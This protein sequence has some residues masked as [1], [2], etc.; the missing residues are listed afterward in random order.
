MGYIE[1]DR[2]INYN[3]AVKSRRQSYQGRAGST[4][5]DTDLAGKIEAALN[6]NSYVLCMNEYFTDEVMAEKVV[7]KNAGI[8]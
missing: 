4:S 2:S 5:E 1:S 8:L 3:C 7:K 6:G